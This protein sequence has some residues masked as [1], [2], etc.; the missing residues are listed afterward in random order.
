LIPSSPHPPVVAAVAAAA[1]AISPA[2]KEKYGLC[3]VLRS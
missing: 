1:A 2:R 3:R